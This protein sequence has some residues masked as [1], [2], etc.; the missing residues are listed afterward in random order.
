M[1][2][3]VKWGNAKLPLKWGGNIATQ[4]RGGQ[5]TIHQMYD[6]KITEKNKVFSQFLFP[7]LSSPFTYLFNHVFHSSARQKKEERDE[8]EE[9]QLIKLPFTR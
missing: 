9:K 6:K 4:K 7:F 1:G 8:E 3:E 2:G 5:A